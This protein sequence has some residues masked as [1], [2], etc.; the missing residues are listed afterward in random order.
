[1]AV[2]DVTRPGVDLLGPARL[3]SRA[4][5]EARGLHRRDEASVLVWQ[6][7]LRSPS[8]SHS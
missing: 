2:V 3:G 8:Q 4:L 6:V 5:P 7:E 1:M